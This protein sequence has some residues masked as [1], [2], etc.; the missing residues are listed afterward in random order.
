[1]QASTS[2]LSFINA[3]ILW[4][5]TLWVK[6]VSCTCILWIIFFLQHAHSF[7]NLAFTLC[8]QASL[9]DL[10][11]FMSVFFQESW[12]GLVLWQFYWLLLFRFTFV[13]RFY[14]L[15]TRHRISSMIFFCHSCPPDYDFNY[16]S[17]IKLV[18][19]VFCVLCMCFFHW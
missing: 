6:S 1:M 19:F 16:L 14:L 8:S 12:S 5:I 7:H 17:A 15:W 13:S 9:F 11:L 2:I 3:C 10:W 18:Y 4:I